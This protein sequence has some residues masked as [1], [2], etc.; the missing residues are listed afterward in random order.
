MPMNTRR[1]RQFFLIGLAA[2]PLFSAL[3]V[4]WLMGSAPGGAVPR[5]RYLRAVYVLQ[6]LGGTAA[7]EREEIPSRVITTDATESLRNHP[8]KIFVLH[9]L[10]DELAAVREESAKAPLFEAYA[11]ISLGELREAARLLTVYVVENEYNAEHYAL[12]SRTLHELGDA[13]SLLLICREWRERDA[14]CLPDRV[15]FTW[16]A[17]YALERYPQAEEAASAEKACLGWSAE[18]YA[19]KAHLASQEDDADAE[20]ALDALLKAHPENAIRMRRLWDQIK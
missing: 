9:H 6:S 7:K 20:V 13:S 10:A 4:Y 5:E 12:L 14:A 11:R 19:A 2:L 15:R 8:D 1:S 18:V 17:L 3:V 16:A